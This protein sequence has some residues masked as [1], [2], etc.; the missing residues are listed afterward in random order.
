MGAAASMQRPD[1]GHLSVQSALDQGYDMETIRLIK[2]QLEKNK[3]ASDLQ[4]REESLNEIKSLRKMLRE[5][6][7][8]GV[9]FQH[10]IRQ[11][12]SHIEF[13]PS[14][15]EFRVTDK[16]TI[17]KEVKN[18]TK[19]LNAYYST[20]KEIV[21]E[22]VLLQPPMY[23]FSEPKD[24]ANIVYVGEKNVKRS[25]HDDVG[26]LQCE[27]ENQ[28]PSSRTISD[29]NAKGYNGDNL[30]GR[31]FYE[32][33]LVRQVIVQPKSPPKQRNI[34]SLETFVTNTEKVDLHNERNNV[35]SLMPAN[36]MNVLVAD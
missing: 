28:T 34:D 29:R 10:I 26:Q 1:I 24:T 8:T 9:H 30:D 6:Y 14:D 21:D 20:E 23:T 31:S 7:A 11:D 3:D 13:K 35:A 5:M 33:F 12:D 18:A 22:S 32:L 25:G 15:Y 36:Q 17:R 4:T 27:Q 16:G 19:M 2:T